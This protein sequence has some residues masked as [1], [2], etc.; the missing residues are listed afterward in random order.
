MKVLHTGTLDVRAGGPAMSTYN[1]LVGLRQQ[2]IE[3]EIVMYE[4]EPGGKL[5]GDEATVHYA[6]RPLRNKMAYSPSLVNEIRDLGEYDVYHAQGVWQ[7]PTYALAAAARKKHKP[8]VITPRGMLYP[9]DIA[10]NNKFFKQLS[11]ALKLKSDLNNAACI[12]CTCVEEMEHLRALGVTTPVAIIANP[13]VIEEHKDIKTDAVFRVGYLGR[14]SPRKKIERL[15]RAFAEL[16][17]VAQNAELLI[18]GNCGDEY[19]QQLH[20]EAEQLGVK[21]I[22]FAGFLSGIEKDDAIASMS[23]LVN[24][25]DFENLGNVI[26]EGLVRRIPCIATTGSPWE[27]LR[28]HDC[29]WWVEP[30]QESITEAIRDAIQTSPTKLEEM[31]RNGYNLVAKNYSVEAIA[32]K[33]KKMYKWILGEIEKPDFVLTTING[34]GGKAYQ[35]DLQRV[36]RE[37]GWRIAA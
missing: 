13:V 34:G 28:T 11:L 31:G 24:P 36:S 3:A 9:Q 8:Y 26:L 18:I 33:T 15:I 32:T 10:K 14:V 12:Q 37:N 7:W 30:T 20:K 16:G 17:D 22:R 35:I 27:E 4:M 25:S 6:K 1:T 29:G 23:V 5:R 19:E 2:G 21:N